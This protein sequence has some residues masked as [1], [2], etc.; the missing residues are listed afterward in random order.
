MKTFRKFISEDEYIL[1]YAGK[2]F[3]PFIVMQPYGE[4]DGVKGYWVPCKEDDP[5]AVE[6][7]QFDADLAQLSVA[8]DKIDRSNKT[9]ISGH[10]EEDSDGHD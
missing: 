10:W 8:P 3:P 2:P 4:K 5:D 9:S 7:M 6:A 1:R